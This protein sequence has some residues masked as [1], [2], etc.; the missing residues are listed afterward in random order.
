[1]T[2]DCTTPTTI[3]LASVTRPVSNPQKSKITISA[4]IQTKN[5]DKKMNFLKI[6]NTKAAFINSCKRK[7]TSLLT[8][9][10]GLKTESRK[11][12]KANEIY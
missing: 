4:M 11:K 2:I 1:M 8:I 5:N 12:A 10:N 9:C 3:C 7:K 6:S